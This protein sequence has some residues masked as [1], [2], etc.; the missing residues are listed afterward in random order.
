MSETA[1]DNYSWYTV[2]VYS[3]SNR[4]T[5]HRAKARTHDEA[6]H[7]IAFRESEMWGLLG[8]KLSD[9]KTSDSMYPGDAVRV[10]I[11]AW[12]SHGGNEGHEKISPYQRNIAGAPMMVM[13]PKVKKVPFS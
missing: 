4:V 12:E 8:G 10:Q 3:G 13:G 2:E 1:S 6:I 5:Q 7:M 9:F 11:T